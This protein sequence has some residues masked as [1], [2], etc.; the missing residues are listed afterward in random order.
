MGQVEENSGRGLVSDVQAPPRRLRKTQMIT[1]L[2]IAVFVY[3]TIAATTLAQVQ[4]PSPTPPPNAQDKD[5]I[6]RITTS[7]VQVDVVVTKNGKVVTDLTPN[8]FEI[9]EDGKRQTITNFLYVSNLSNAAPMPPVTA[10]KNNNVSAPSPPPVELNTARRIMALVIDDLGLSAESINH[11][12]RQLRKFVDEQMQSNDLVAIIRTGAD[13]GALQQF[14]NDKRLLHSAINQAQWNLCS[15]VGTTVF[16][17]V[18]PNT[19]PLTTNAGS[20]CGW[21]SVRSSLS[22]LRFILQAMGDLPGRKSMVLFSDSIPRQEQDIMLRDDDPGSQTDER[23]YYGLLQRLAEIAI[24]NSVVIYGVDTQGLQ[25]AASTA[26]DTVSN[27]NLKGGVDSQMINQQVNA[28]TRAR[29]LEM[30][31]RREGADVLSKDTGGFLVKNSNDFKLDHIMDD[32]QGY[33]LLGYR[34]NTETFNR[35]FHHISAK[36]KRSGLS[37]RTRKGFY[38]FTE[39]EANQMRQAQSSKIDAVLVSPFRAHDIAIDLAT[40]FAKDP[41]LGLLLRSFL[42]IDAKS[43]TFQDDGEGWRKVLVEMRGIIF[44]NNGRPLDEIVVTPT[45][46]LRQSTYE[47]ALRDGLVLRFDMTVKR[48]GAYQL[49]VAARDLVSSRIGSAGQ[50]VTVPDATRE[51]AMSGI[52]LSGETEQRILTI[53]APSQ[54]DVTNAKVEAHLS[55][56]P[57]TRKFKAGSNLVFGF[58]IYNANTSD[59]QPQLTVDAKLFREGKL[60]DSADGLRVNTAGQ[61]DLTRISTS[62]VVYLKPELQPGRYYLQLVTVDSGKKKNNAVQWIDFEIIKP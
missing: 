41:R 14:T 46:R 45:V 61:K 7:L 28:I 44:G 50:F 55:P 5:D 43:L 2:H 1:K 38:G 40:I 15:R 30:I 19:V 22:S 62:G 12:R 26:A 24:R 59:G 48:P 16:R 57:V 17:P 13:I 53:S 29:M 35:R 18:Q 20:T 9:F 34:P 32:Q 23:N 39:D 4:Q 36:V 31:R 47:Q 52:V 60:V 56:N 49:R 51:F 10:T 33:Y 8:D 3:F 21:E 37:L 54:S 11:V 42:Y 6:V 58:V 27:S 25:S